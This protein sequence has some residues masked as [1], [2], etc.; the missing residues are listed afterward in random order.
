MERLSWII[1]VGPM[2]SRGCL[3]LKEADEEGQRK[4][5]DDGSRVREVLHCWL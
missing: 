3:K 1:R 2:S 5:W 4:R